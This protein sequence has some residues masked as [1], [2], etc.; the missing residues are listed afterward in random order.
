MAGFNERWEEAQRRYQQ[1]YR[2]Y[3][4]PDFSETMKRFI[5]SKDSLSRLI[6]INIALWLLIVLINVLYFLF[7]WSK[8]AGCS[9]HL[10]YYLSLPSGIESLIHRPWG[11]FTYMFVHQKFLHLFFNMIVLYY[12]GKIFLKFFNDKQLLST[13]IIGGLFGALFYVAGMNIFPVFSSTVNTSIAIG[14]SA[15]VMAILI[16]AATYAPD[17]DV[18]LFY[19]INMKFKWVAVIIIILDIMGIA[20]GNSGG[21]IAHLGGALWGFT[22]GL[23]SRKQGSDIFAGIKKKYQK[24]QREQKAKAEAENK[25]KQ[26]K[27]A[28]D[29]AAKRKQKEQD[30]IDEILKKVSMSGYSSLTEEEKKILFSKSKR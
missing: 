15:S 7:Q 19:I 6:I 26:E 13:Y 22:Y 17:L 24:Y 16:A 27:K 3:G 21:H 18:N 28:M 20:G 14:A 1:Q 11:I 25:K 2:Q 9:N 4:R 29:D 23:L 12:S 5:N 8:P 10:V 30:K